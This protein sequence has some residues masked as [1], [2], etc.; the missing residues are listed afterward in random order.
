MLTDDEVRDLFSAYHDR[1][2]SP[3]RN[4]AVRAALDANA[5]LKR[6]YDAFVRMLAGLSAM[7][8][9]SE[10][11]LP[12][13]SPPQPHDP[14]KPADAPDL[15]GGVQRR[16]QKRSGG[17]FY[18]DGWSRLAGILPLELL[19]TLVLIALV[20]AYAAMTMVSTR[21]APAPAGA[22]APSAPR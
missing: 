2:L 9:A 13:V 18:G 21:P 5:A 15:L 14:A 11:P 20:V 19:A 7:A 22:T 4:D 8:A 6:E 10:A 1:E 12:G 3:E 17:K 16:L